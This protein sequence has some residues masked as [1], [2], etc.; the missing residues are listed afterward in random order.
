MQRRI[1]QLGKV[2]TTI[3]NNTDWESTGRWATVGGGIGLLLALLFSRKNRLRNAAIATGIGAAAGGYGAMVARNVRTEMGGHYATN[4]DYYDTSE[5]LRKAK[6]L[7]NDSIVLYV[8]GAND[9][10]GGAD[11]LEDLP[12]VFTYRWGDGKYLARAI[13]ALRR[14]GHKVDVVGH[15]AGATAIFDALGED[16]VNINSVHLLDPVDLSLRPLLNKVYN[17]YLKLLKGISKEAIIH[18]A[19]DRTYNSSDPSSEPNKSI[20]FNPLAITQIPGVKQ[21]NHNDNHGMHTTG[22]RMPW[23]AEKRA[24]WAD[25]LPKKIDNYNAHQQ[26]TLS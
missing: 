17:R 23:E 21:I 26:K 22:L 11:R 13:K 1:E 18:S 2:L 6:N 7:N 5:L 14:A 19:L 8:S 9:A 20:A 16:K 24:K 4:P 15:S 25:N 12:G 3:P 10:P